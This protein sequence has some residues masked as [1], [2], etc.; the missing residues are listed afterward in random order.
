M[1]P[2]LVEFLTQDGGN[3]VPLAQSVAQLT[4]LLAHEG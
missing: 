3:V 2:A 1:H 4:Q